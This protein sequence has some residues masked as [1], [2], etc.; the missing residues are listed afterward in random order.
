MRPRQDLDIHSFPLILYLVEVNQRHGVYLNEG[1][2]ILIHNTVKDNTSDDGGG[3][4]LWYSA[5]TLSE[6]AVLSNSAQYGG[7]LYLWGRNATLTNT[8]VAD[9]QASASGSGLHLTAASFRLLHTTIANNQ[10]GDGSGV[11]VNG[12]AGWGFGTVSLTNTILVSQAVGILVRDGNTAT[13]DSTL[14]DG[15]TANW[16]GAGTVNHSHH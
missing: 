7:G 9:N 8:L 12:D 14:W 15:N 11:Y 3:L 2:A 10:G 13:L 5:A 6:N 4:Y 16:G 1:E